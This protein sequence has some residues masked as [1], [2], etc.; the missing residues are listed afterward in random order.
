MER[1]L[2]SRERVLR[3]LDFKPVDKPALFCEI[4]AAGYYEHG[5]KLRDLIRSL[6]SDFGPMYEG[7]FQLPGPEDF[8]S[9][10]RYHVVK[11]DAWGVTWEYRIYGVAGHPIAWPI[12]DW[13]KLDGYEFPEQH[14]WSSEELAEKRGAIDR[15][16]NQGYFIN[17]G[18]IA[19]FQRAYE[20]RRYE[21]ALMDIASRDKDFLRY[22]MHMHEFNRLSVENL[23]AEGV[24]A[25]QFA[26]DFG[27]QDALIISPQDFR[28]IYKPLYKELVAMVKKAGKRAFFHNCGYAWPLLED[29]MEIGFDQIWPQLNV[30]DLKTFAKRCRELHLAVAIHPERSLLM[31]FGKP[32]EIKKRILEYH[33]V[34]RPQDG[35]SYYFLEIDNG[36]PYE[37]IVAMVEAVRELRSA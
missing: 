19:Y 12:D 8:D 23:L 15:L 22:T 18:W 16:R 1:T 17:R 7:D 30:Y 33:E 11:T 27:T 32:D 36:F 26:D 29:Y 13:S 3:M 20:V 37:N 24:D 4:S 34:F 35:G 21:D 14:K 10:G 6:N 9:D 2:T 28:E 5:E 31:T 25:I